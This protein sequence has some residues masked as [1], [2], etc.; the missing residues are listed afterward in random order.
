[1]EKVKR[2]EGMDEAEKVEKVKKGEPSMGY[3][4]LFDIFQIVL[5]LEG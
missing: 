2:V 5:S 4:A 1:M 3:I